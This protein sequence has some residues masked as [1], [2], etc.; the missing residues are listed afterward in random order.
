MHCVSGM[1]HVYSVS[2]TSGAPAVQLTTGPRQITH[3]SV[4]DATLLCA[5]KDEHAPAELLQFS[6]PSDASAP[7][8][9]LA[10]AL[11]ALNASVLAELDTASCE[12][13]SFTSWDGQ[14]RN[15]LLCL[16]SSTSNAK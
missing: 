9:E 8:T 5:M 2:P 11:T 15:T 1:R 3:F 4:G 10:P 6:M 16:P 14:V 12:Q 7:A 13:F